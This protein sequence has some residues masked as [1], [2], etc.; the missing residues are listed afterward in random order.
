[1]GYVKYFF[2][3]AGGFLISRLTGGTPESILIFAVL[4][5]VCLAAE[6]K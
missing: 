6:R 2:Y 3:C 5:E 1:M 4:L